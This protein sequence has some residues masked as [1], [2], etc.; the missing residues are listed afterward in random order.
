MSPAAAPEAAVEAGQRGRALPWHEQLAA[1]LAGGRLPT[2]TMLVGRLADGLEQLALAIAG[3]L[4]EKQGIQSAPL[5]DAG[6]HP[7]LLV[8]RRQPNTTGKLRQEITIDQV[9]QLIEFMQLTPR[10]A[11]L[12]IAVIVPACRLNRSSANALLKILE[13]PPDP[14]RFI[15][16]AEQPERLPATVRSRTRIVAAPAPARAEALAWLKKNHPQ[17]PDPEGAL[18]AAAGAPVA[19]AGLREHARQREAFVK[20]VLGQADLV[21]TSRDLAALPV[22]TWLEWAQY[23]V[24][25]LVATGLGLEPRMFPEA[26]GSDSLVRILEAGR[27]LQEMRRLARHPVNARQLLERVAIRLQQLHRQP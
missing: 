26:S 10:I 23:W 4:L 27:E 9:R 19:V 6:T 22:E 7:D 8:L 21:A 16:A 3:R 13:E 5:L 11:K 17:L 20:L 1:Q 2:A 24:G 25:D 14:G 12:R 15:L 18:A